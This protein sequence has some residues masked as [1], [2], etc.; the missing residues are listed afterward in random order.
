MEQTPSYLDRRIYSAVWGTAAAV[1]MM[2]T[3][4]LPWARTPD[5][6]GGPP[7]DYYTLWH[8]SERSYNHLA[9]PARFLLV[10]MLIAVAAV[11][12]A[13]ARATA[14]SYVG[15]GVVAAIAAADEIYV[16]SRTGPVIGQAATGVVAATLLTLTIV[17]VYLTVGFVWIRSKHYS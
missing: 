17:V 15:A 5:T 12:T 14:G 1:A 8:L 4:A 6:A 13:A 9:T 3:W 7:S 16:W 2:I 10:V 11:L